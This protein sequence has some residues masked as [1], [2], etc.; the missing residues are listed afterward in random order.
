VCGRQRAA[1]GARDV[2]AC[3][4]LAHFVLLVPPLTRF[5]LQIFCIEVDQ[6]MN[7]KVV[8]LATL[9][10]FYKGYIGFFLT[11]FE[12]FECQY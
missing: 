4:T 7:T 12:L 11:E 6:V 1:R 3:N 8:Y 2:A 9:N 10:N 5:F